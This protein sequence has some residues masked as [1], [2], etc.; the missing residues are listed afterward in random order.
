MAAL[1]ALGR[2]SYPH[3]YLVR[4]FGGFH[5]AEAA[6]LLGGLSRQYSEDTFA[7]WLTP[8]DRPILAHPR[9]AQR[10]DVLGFCAG[11]IQPKLDR[12]CM[13]MG[14]ELRAPYLDRRVLEWGLSMSVDPREGQTGKLPIRAMLA[15]GVED[16]LVPR[17]ILTRPK[18]GFSLRMPDGEFAGLES[19]VG[20]SRLVRD[21]VL[22]PDWERFL[23]RD[24]GA[25]RV[26]LF[27]LAMVA[28]W[29]E[30]RA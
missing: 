23:V 17:Q 16:G 28:A 13:A 9:R 20:E 10:L 22:R 24:P 21:G 19:V 27:T 30:T 18:Q 29:Y 11:S 3:R 8:E 25:R 14:L 4:T 15:R 6:A 7:A 2:L 26:R 1:H 12:A 5:P